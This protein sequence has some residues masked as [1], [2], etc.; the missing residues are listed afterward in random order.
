M[1]CTT[2]K[3]TFLFWGYF[4][5][6]DVLLCLTGTFVFVGWK[7]TQGF[8]KHS[9]LAFVEDCLVSTRAVDMSLAA[10]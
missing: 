10:K 8:L 9:D 2:Y 1:M 4:C 5:V 7:A 6:L 3:Q